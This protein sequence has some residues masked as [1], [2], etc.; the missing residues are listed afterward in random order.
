MFAFRRKRSLGCEQ[1]EGRFAP[2]SVMVG[3]GSRSAL[4]DAQALE[5]TQAEQA[6]F[7]LAASAAVGQGS[8]VAKVE[9]VS[10][11]QWLDFSEMPL[12]TMYQM[13]DGRIRCI[14]GSTRPMHREG[15]VGLPQSTGD[16]TASVGHAADDSGISA[17][18]PF[19]NPSST[20]T[21][22]EEQPVG[23]ETVAAEDFPPVFDDT[24]VAGDEVAEPV[25][26]DTGMPDASHTEEMPRRGN[27]FEDIGPSYPMNTDAVFADAD[28]SDEI[29]LEDMPVEC[30]S[31]DATDEVAPVD[32]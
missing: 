8:S 18:P 25:V 28:G 13:P 14:G 17:E 32:A 10:D 31:D 3:A 19:S 22:F 6:A 1:L 15:S 12:F 26:E 29:A 30:Q 2:S 16:G 20:G 9:P 5:T 24:P 4:R 27:D 21:P 7:F 23:G 11:V